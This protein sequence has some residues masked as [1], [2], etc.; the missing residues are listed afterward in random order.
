MRVTVKTGILFAALWITIKMVMYLGGIVDS[1]IPGTLINILCLLL[2][3]SVGLY[4]KKKEGNTGNALNDIK[5]GISAGLPYTLIISLFLYF[6]YGSV[7][8]DFID[9]KINERIT[10]VDKYLENPNN[11][12]Q[13]KSENSSYETY[14]IEQFKEEEA[15]KT[16]TFNSPKALMIM[17]MLGGL[18]LGVFYSIFVTIIY[19]KLLFR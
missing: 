16:R 12:N 19:R 8:K 6:F 5:D 1:Q 14:T 3:I 15:E 18:M 17:S 13:I 7:D 2:A 9:H 11:W 10:A 4:L